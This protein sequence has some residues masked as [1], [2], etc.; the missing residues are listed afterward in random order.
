ME[1]RKEENA[2]KAQKTSMTQE[3]VTVEKK[4]EVSSNIWTDPNVK[5]VAGV[6]MLEFIYDYVSHERKTAMEQF[7][8]ERQGPG[9]QTVLKTA[10]E[11]KEA[12]RLA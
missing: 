8:N 4:E 5:N 1:R 11:R 6:M 3:T 2:K 7:L 10:N 9:N 12:V